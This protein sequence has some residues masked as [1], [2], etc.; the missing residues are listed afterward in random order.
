MRGRPC[1]SV[2]ELLLLTTDTT[3]SYQQ[4]LTTY[5]KRWG[6]EDYH[7]SL[8]I[9]PS[10]QNS[11]A[12]NIITQ[13]NHLLASVCAFVKLERLKIAE[14]TNQF[15]LKGRLY[16]KAI[17]A[18]LAELKLLQQKNLPSNIDLA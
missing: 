18:A 8:K 17:Q 1:G 7:K 14:C 4:I 2:G 16:L 13:S 6:I 15:A 9:N 12:R 3:M 5:Q 11:P 10:L